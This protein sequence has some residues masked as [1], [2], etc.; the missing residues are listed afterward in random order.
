VADEIEGFLQ[1]ADQGEWTLAKRQER[2][3]RLG[4]WI[5]NAEL[6]VPSRPVNVEV[7]IAVAEVAAE[8]VGAGD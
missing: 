2:F 7:P 8:A 1:A 4:Q 3:Q 5:E 6:P